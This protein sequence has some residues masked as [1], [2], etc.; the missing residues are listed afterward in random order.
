MFQEKVLAP[1]ALPRAK[2]ID[3]IVEVWMIAP[4]G[5]SCLGHLRKKYSHFPTASP[6]HLLPEYERGFVPNLS[7]P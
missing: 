4:A 5:S 3:A 2:D 7:Q 1:E 6:L